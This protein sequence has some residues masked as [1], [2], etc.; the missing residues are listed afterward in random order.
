MKQFCQLKSIDQ[1]QRITKTPQV[2]VT[3]G[4]AGSPQT[5]VPRALAGFLVKMEIGPVKTE[6]CFETRPVFLFCDD[7]LSKWLRV[8]VCV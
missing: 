2:R 8:V 6:L 5:L 1:N 4:D 7:Q 3:V